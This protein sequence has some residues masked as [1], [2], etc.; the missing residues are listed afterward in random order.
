MFYSP[1]SMVTLSKASG[2]VQLLSLIGRGG[3]LWKGL[4]K[5]GR[6]SENG[7]VSAFRK[8][9]SIFRSPVPW[10]HSEQRQHYAS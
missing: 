2:A 9:L 8:H 4:P 6:K 5:L 3:Q 1:R 10:I 7:K